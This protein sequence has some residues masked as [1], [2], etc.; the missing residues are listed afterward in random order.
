METFIYKGFGLPATPDTLLV[1]DVNALLY[2]HIQEASIYQD[3]N[4]IDHP[5]TYTIF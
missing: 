1:N 4:N 5:L 3:I 2:K